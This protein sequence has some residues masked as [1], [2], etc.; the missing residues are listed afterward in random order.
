M[1]VLS[2]KEIVCVYGGNCVCY[3][4]END[5]DGVPQVASNA[6]NCYNICCT[7]LNWWGWGWKNNRFFN[8]NKVSCASGRQKAKDADFAANVPFSESCSRVVKSTTQ[9]FELAAAMLPKEESI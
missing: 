5:V 7:T 2:F 3:L 9:Q 8:V 1:Y 4:L 6:E